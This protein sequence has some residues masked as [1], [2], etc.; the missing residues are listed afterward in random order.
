[1]QPNPVFTPDAV[2]AL[3]ELFGAM[4][5][6]DCLIERSSGRSVG[7]APLPNAWQPVA[8]TKC[9]VKGSGLMVSERIA[10]GRWGPDLGLVVRIR[11]DPEAEGFDIRPD[12]RIT[13]NG[14]YLY[15][16]AAPD[17]STWGWELEVP[18]RAES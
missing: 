5:Q 16:T 7:G 18:C 17:T 6:S 1:M 10:A 9:R 11:R 14:D 13:V 3:D 4:R 15:V 2:K 8:T 12:D